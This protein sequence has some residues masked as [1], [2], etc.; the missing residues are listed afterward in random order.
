MGFLDKLLGRA[1]QP[2]LAGLG[3]AV[4]SDKPAPAPR[5]TTAPSIVQPF[6]AVETSGPEV[7]ERL[8][9]SMAGRRGGGTPAAD[10]M[11]AAGGP[12]EMEAIP[13]VEGTPKVDDVFD[14]DIP[15]IAGFQRWIVTDVWTTEQGHKVASLRSIDGAH[16]AT[17][18]IEKV[19]FA[20][21]PKDDPNAPPVFAPHFREG[22]VVEKGGA[23]ARHKAFREH[24][25]LVCKRDHLHARGRLGEAEQAHAEIDAHEKKHGLRM[26]GCGLR[27]RRRHPK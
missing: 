19:A 15:P 1:P 11:P 5:R 23:P 3:S 25:E 9:D 27:A 24:H 10:P 6:P 22:V 13:H 7:A 18:P 16:F 2:A 20:K 12:V 8:S 17:V 26:G 4:A 14:L 21:G